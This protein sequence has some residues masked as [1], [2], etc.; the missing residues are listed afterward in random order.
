MRF[1]PFILRSAVVAALSFAAFVQCRAADSRKPVKVFVLAGQSN[2][3]GKAKVSLLEYQADAPKTR[4]ECSH[5]KKDG[6]WIVRDDVWIKFLDRKGNL[7]VGFGSEGCIGPELEFGI[8]VGDHFDEQVLLIKTAWGG[9]SLYRDFRPPSSGLPPDDVLQAIVDRAKRPKGNSSPEV[10]LGAVKAAFGTSYRQMLQEVDGTLKNLKTEFPEYQGQGCEIAGFTW[11]QGWNDLIDPVATAEYE[12]NMVNFIRDVRR[13]LKRPNLPFVIG[14][15]GFDGAAG[16]KN[17]H[18]KALKA[19]QAAACE[20]PEFRGNV[21]MVKTDLFWDMDAEAVFKKGWR[22]H[23]AEWNT[24]GSDYG[25]HYYGSARTYSK[26]GKALGEAM[27]EL[28]D[29]K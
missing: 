24:V 27:I 21:K 26:I 2:M 12:K 15:V 19:A 14:Q 28:L 1:R 8:A 7:T 9:K 29:K 16:E 22:E 18:V 6:K 23:Q 20:V 25:Y 17:P 13:D 3:E 4:Q 11:F 10:T 5:L